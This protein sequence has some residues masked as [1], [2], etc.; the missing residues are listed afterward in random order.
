MS[1]VFGAVLIALVAL[2]V[3]VWVNLRVRRERAAMSPEER[4]A[5]DAEVALKLSIW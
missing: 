3:P 5:Q 4:A 2:A 1:Q